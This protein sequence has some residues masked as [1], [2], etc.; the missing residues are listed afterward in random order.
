M[1]GF[2][3]LGMALLVDMPIA[4]KQI[5]L[6]EQAAGVYCGKGTGTVRQSRCGI[7]LCHLPNET[8]GTPHAPV[9]LHDYDVASYEQVGEC[10][11]R[12]HPQEEF[13]LP[14]FVSGRLCMRVELT[15]QSA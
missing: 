5:V 3:D 9:D 14:D 15:H 12:E 4:R 8:T 10:R 2:G 1:D 6:V 13:R 11:V 7:L